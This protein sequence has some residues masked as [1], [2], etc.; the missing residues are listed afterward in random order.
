MTKLETN[1]AAPDFKVLDVNGQEFQLS[2]LK[3]EKNI[4][5]VL[6]RGFA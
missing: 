2:K 6:N 4:Y 1:K 5:L 3:G